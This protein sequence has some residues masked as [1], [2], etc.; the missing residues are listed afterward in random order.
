MRMNATLISKNETL[1]TRTREIAGTCHEP[2]LGE[3]FGILGEAIDKSAHN[4]RFV[5][6]SPVKTLEKT[7]TGW[8]FTTA[9]GSHYEL[10]VG[11]QE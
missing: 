3:P 5:A 7:E 9:S 10:V 1:T 11:S 6:T 8:T 2:V 4:V